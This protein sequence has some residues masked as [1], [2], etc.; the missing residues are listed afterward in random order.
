MSVLQDININVNAQPSETRAPTPLMLSQN[1]NGRL[2]YFRILGAQI[3]AGST[4]VF[5]G[6]KP[7]GNVYSTTGTVDGNFV[8]VAEAIQMTAVAGKWDAKLDIINDTHNVM[9]AR[10]RVIVDPDVVDP[11]AIESDSDLQGLVAEAKYFAENARS[12]S[13]GSPLTA[14]TAADMVNQSRVY[15]YTGSE[16]GYTAGHWY[17]H[18]G[19][20][21]TDG[22]V[23]NA[24][25]A[26]GYV[27]GISG[28][29]L[30]IL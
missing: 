30:M 17:Y 5:S 23:Y 2:I 4:A 14:H 12:E 6:T 7:D 22:G 8:I 16:T 29:A 18:N 24:V 19:T 21:W 13:Y 10:I 27:A 9:T 3:P 25:A 26:D 15:V 20:A 11:D 28:T 1:E